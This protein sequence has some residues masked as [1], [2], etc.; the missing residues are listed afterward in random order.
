MP[1]LEEDVFHVSFL[2]GTQ[3]VLLF[4]TNM[5]VA[6]DCQLAGDLEALEQEATISIH[7]V[8]LSLVNNIA[9]SELLYLCIAR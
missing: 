8:G 3:R 2:D 6:E 9:K 7:G 4:T 5:K 1:D